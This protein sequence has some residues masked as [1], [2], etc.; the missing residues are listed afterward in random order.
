[1]NTRKV[2]LHSHIFK[3]AGSTLDWA[4]ERN[5]GRA[6]YDHR[7]DIYM[8]KQG[9]KYL[10]E[11]IQSRP[12]LIAVSSHHMPFM[13]EQEKDYWWLILL[14][15]PIRRVKSVYDFEVKQPIS[16]LGSKRAKELDFSEYILWRMQDDAPTTIKNFHTRYLNNVMNP[17]R[18]IDESYV[19]RAFERLRLKNVIFGSVER[20]DESMIIFEEALKKDFP[21]I[22]LEY[23]KQN[24]SRKEGDSPLGI[25]NDLTAE[26]RDLLLEKN[27][28]DKDLYERVD[29]ELQH[30]TQKIPDFE[31][32]LNNL[33]NRRKTL[34]I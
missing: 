1:M 12:E 26:A 14:R 21:G 28:L 16:S 15:D 24:V 27:R 22:N 17:S 34:V 2:I 4:L 8:R 20:F 18:I 13:P 5:F 23:I 7:D 9:M 19:D 6:F 31:S 33:Q 3:N 29:T 10:N 25:L 30:L 11:F 32:K